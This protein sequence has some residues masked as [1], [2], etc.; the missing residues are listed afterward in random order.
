M[1]E[2]EVRI[3]KNTCLIGLACVLVA[4]VVAVFMVSG[5]DGFVW[6][7]VVKGCIWVKGILQSVWLELMM[8]WSV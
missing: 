1:D 5:G 2:V 4:G 8:S 3:I 7:C 6:G